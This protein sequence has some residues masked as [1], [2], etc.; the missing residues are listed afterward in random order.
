MLTHPT[1]DKLQTLQLAGLYH[2]LIAQLQMSDIAARSFEERCGL[3]VDR[4]S[5]ARD[6]RRL[7]TRLR[8]AKLR[9]TAC[10]E[11]IDYPGQ[12]HL[13]ILLKLGR[14]NLDPIQH[15]FVWL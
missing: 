2:A 10:L 5:T 14:D 11:E 12:A 6:P 4:E 15:A 13:I 7:T 9:Q 3:L 1:L 8:Q